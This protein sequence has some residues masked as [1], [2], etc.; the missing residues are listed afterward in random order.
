MAP[1][2]SGGGASRLRRPPRPE[3]SDQ[4]PAPI[5]DRRLAPAPI[6]WA[7]SWWNASI[8]FSALSVFTMILVHSQMADHLAAVLEARDASI[9]SAKVFAAA[10]LVSYTVL[11]LVAAVMLTEW[12][13]SRHL[14]RRGRWRRWLLL[15]LGLLHLLIVA[16]AI[17]LVQPEG[18]QGVI[19]NS[20]LIS[21]AL[22][23]IVAS[24]LAFPRSV[25]RWL[26]GE[27]AN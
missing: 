19:L 20:S 9:E 27:E 18:W 3:S 25:G 17:L 23:A 5:A 21:G 4:T 16:T 14:D 15:L 2:D 1:T 22:L 6:Q 24:T 12:R 8:L 7:K 13:V 10:R 26:R 11:G